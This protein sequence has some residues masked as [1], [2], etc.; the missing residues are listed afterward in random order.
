M[1]HVYAF[2]VDLGDIT[3]PA[4]LTYYRGEGYRIGDD[5]SG[6]GESVPVVEAAVPTG[7]SGAVDQATAAGLTTQD[8]ADQDQP[9][10]SRR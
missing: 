1:P 5:D 3:D 4:L 9:S 7:A 10:R 6:S 8:T 2:G